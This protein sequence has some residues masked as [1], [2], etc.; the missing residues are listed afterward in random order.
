MI[1]GEQLTGGDQ[2]GRITIGMIA[3]D[4]EA[5]T[6]HG[7]IK[8]SDYK[9]SWVIL[10][11]HPADF[12]PVCTTEFVEFSKKYEEFKK[13]GVKLIGLS[14]DGLNSHIAWVRDIKE[15]MGVDVPFPIIADLDTKIS[16][17]YGMIH[18]PVSH[19]MPV[20]SVFII[21]PKMVVK[22]IIFYPSGVGRNI[23]E[24]L[25]TIDALQVVDRHRVDTPANWQPGEP[26]LIEPPHTQHGAEDRLK[27]GY[28][29]NTWYLCMKKI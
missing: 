19:I 29:C 12:T 3:P 5:I 24:L 2:S 16:R 11:S 10:F 15:H 21:D 26:V 17:L 1:S 28:E 20:R 4:F 27:E 8:L 9:G 13:R 7:K 22:M 18:P 6:T 14:V 25:R 23:D